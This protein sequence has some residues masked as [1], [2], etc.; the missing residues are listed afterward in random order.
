MLVNNM[1]KQTSEC[2]PC[3]MKKRVQVSW[4]QMVVQIL[5]SQIPQ[6]IWLQW[7]MMSK[8]P[9]HPTFLYNTHLCTSESTLLETFWVAVSE[10]NSSSSS[11]IDLSSAGEMVSGHVSNRQLHR[12]DLSPGYQNKSAPASNK[13]RFQLLDYLD[14]GDLK[15]T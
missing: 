10:S 9:F 11:A 12:T 6:R 8:T 4:R 5:L 3:A 14:T 1:I 15:N 2:W 13:I 7:P